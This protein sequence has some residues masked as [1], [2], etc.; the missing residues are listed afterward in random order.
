M[1]AATPTRTDAERLLRQL[2]DPRAELITTTSR[3]LFESEALAAAFQKSGWFATRVDRAPVFN[4]VTLLHA[5]YQACR[6]P[7][8]FGFNWDALRDCL[9]DF[10]WQPAH[11]YVLLFQNLELLQTRAPDE[12]GVLLDVLGEARDIW[13]EASGVPFRVLLAT[14]A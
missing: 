14:A 6:F 12:H 7:A 1:S 8:Y 3:A 10:S 5:I 2:A 4:K 13:A 11:G 9:T